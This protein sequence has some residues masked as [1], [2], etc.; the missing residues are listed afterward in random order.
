MWLQSLATSYQ[1]YGILPD[2]RILFKVNQLPKALFFK[3]QVEHTHTHHIPFQIVLKETRIE[4]PDTRD[5]YGPVGLVKHKRSTN[6]LVRCRLCGNTSY[7]E[8]C[9]LFS[10]TLS[11]NRNSAKHL[12]PSWTWNS[13]SQTSAKVSGVLELRDKFWDSLCTQSPQE[14]S[15]YNQSSNHNS[16]TTKWW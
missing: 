11:L 4:T 3:R 9:M 16:W 5:G 10:S 13:F 12:P 15:N 6:A 14:N 8:I 7:G 1:L 2:A